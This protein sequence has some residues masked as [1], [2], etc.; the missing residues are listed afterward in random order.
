MIY[1]SW[2]VRCQV[3][4]CASGLAGPCGG[5]AH[6]DPGHGEECRHVRDLDAV[7]W[8]F[9]A[10]H[11]ANLRWRNF[12]ICFRGGFYD[13]FQMDPNGVSGARTCLNKQDIGPHS[14][15]F[16]SRTPTWTKAL[17]FVNLYWLCQRQP[18]SHPRRRCKK[19]PS[20]ID[21]TVVGVVEQCRTWLLTEA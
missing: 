8:P 11:T 4:W 19:P 21:F 10:I 12:A 6:A 15:L 1:S 7:R 13:C 5:E 20:S 18:W 17:H 2:D 14:I 16:L 3:R 9:V